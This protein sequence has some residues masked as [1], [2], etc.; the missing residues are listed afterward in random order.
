MVY[1]A[2][3]WSSSS[4]TIIQHLQVR[5]HDT[6]ATAEDYT[7]AVVAGGELILVLLTTRVMPIN[8]C[9][10]DHADHAN[11]NGTD[12]ADGVD[13]ADDAGD[14]DHKDDEDDQRS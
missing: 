6:H 4:T 10:A 14:E 5:L 12:D 7:G 1:Y 3:V 9:D 2:L 8:A 11:E 13:G